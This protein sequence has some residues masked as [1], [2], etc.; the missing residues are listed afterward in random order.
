MLEIVP[1]NQFK[2]AVIVNFVNVTLNQIGSLF[3]E[4]IKMFSNY[5]YFARARIQICFNT[6]K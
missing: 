2:Q 3:I 1:S 6:Q 5:F 4:L